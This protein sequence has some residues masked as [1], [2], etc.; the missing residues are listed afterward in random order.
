MSLAHS[1]TLPLMYS[2]ACTL[3]PMDWL[4]FHASNTKEYKI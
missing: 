4:K 3:W 1:L 2:L